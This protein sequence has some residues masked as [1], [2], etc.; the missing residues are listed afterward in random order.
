MWSGVQLERFVSREWTSCNLLNRSLDGPP[1][2]SGGD[3]EE[4]KYFYLTGNR[5]VTPI[6]DIMRLQ[7]F[8]NY[9]ASEQVGS[10]GYR[11]PWRE[12]YCAILLRQFSNSYKF[13]VCKSVHH[14]TIQ[15][16]HQPDAT[17]FQFIVLTFIYSS[18]CFGRSPAHHQELNDC[19]S[20]LWF[21]LFS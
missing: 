10:V 18:T 12:A 16:N 3:E 9:A 19:S 7:S 13:K 21:Y 8:R 15:I 14:R 4:K 20:S 11:H 17:I 2:R 1:C 5:T 6:S